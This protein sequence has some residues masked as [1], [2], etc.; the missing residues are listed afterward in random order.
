MVETL[1]FGTNLPF[2]V[3]NL[4]DVELE[5]LLNAEHGSLTDG[6]DCPKC[7]NRGYIWH[8]RD[9]ERC[10][11]RCSCMEIRASLTRLHKSGL[12]SAAKNCRFDKF[13]VSED[14][15][16]AMLD[17][18][19]A[20]LRDK[21]RQWM[22]VSGQTG[23]GKTHIC[24]ATAVKL[25]K[26][27]AKTRYVQ[28]VEQARQLQ[29]AIFDDDAYSAQIVP[30]KTAKVLY[31]DDFLKTRSNGNPSDKEFALAFELLNARY[32]NPQL[33]TIIS[34]EHTLQELFAF[35]AALAGRIAERCGQYIIQIAPAD[36]RNYRERF[37]RMV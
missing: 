22:F 1:Q 28:W 34:T 8:M 35:D 9:G 3:P 31:I 21:D 24:T 20:F 7:L 11:E 6:Y 2:D 32:N 17:T 23:C 25:L 26:A 33:I 15:Q 36:G 12:E 13:Q 29:A 14:W 19:K 27:G 18:A 10:T 30:L 5:R 4:T 37:A 16:Q